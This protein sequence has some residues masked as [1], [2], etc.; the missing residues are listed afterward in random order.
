VFFIVLHQYK[1]LI[2]QKGKLSISQKKL[3][4]STNLSSLSSWS[5][6]SLVRC[7]VM[8]QLVSKKRLQVF[9]LAQEI[10]FV[11]V[12]VVLQSPLI[13]TGSDNAFSA[14]RNWFVSENDGD[15]SCSPCIILLDILNHLI[16]IISSDIS[17]DYHDKIAAIDTWLFRYNWRFVSRYMY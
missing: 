11:A 8:L 6:S 5:M 17:L 14:I 1:H 3:Q 10:L 13:I 15:S 2:C 7:H 12:T 4:N 16:R 9:L